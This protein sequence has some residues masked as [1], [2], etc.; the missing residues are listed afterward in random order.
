[1][2][3]GV[4]VRSRTDR[5]YTGVVLVLR[6]SRA[7]L[8]AVS[9][10]ALVRDDVVSER[11]RC[12]APSAVIY[13]EFL[14]NMTNSKRYC[15]WIANE[16][17]AVDC[18][19]DKRKCEVSGG[20]TYIEVNRRHRVQGHRTK[21]ESFKTSLDGRY[22]S[23]CYWEFKW[24]FKNCNWAGQEF[25][26]IDKDNFESPRKRYSRHCGKFR[27]GWLPNG[28]DE[29]N[30]PRGNGSNNYFV[31]GAFGK[32]RCFRNECDEDNYFAVSRVIVGRR[33]KQ[34]R[35]EIIISPLRKQRPFPRTGDNHPFVIEC[36]QVELIVG[37][38]DIVAA[39]QISDLSVSSWIATMN[40]S[41]QRKYR[42]LERRETK[43]I[44]KMPKLPEKVFYRI[45]DDGSGDQSRNKK[46]VKFQ[47]LGEEDNVTTCVPFCSDFSP[48]PA[49]YCVRR[50][51]I[52]HGW[53][54]QSLVL[55]YR[56]RDD[57]RQEGPFTSC[58][59]VVSR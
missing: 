19:G 27:R 32:R 43:K 1:M 47:L 34:N 11:L 33:E 42:S 18:S 25:L 58:R 4:R 8:A 9:F 5:G 57:V 51:C 20:S 44:P 50:P 3:R 13:C 59:N 21:I 28:I 56:L 36:K 35:E 23:R 46:H 31:I 2:R 29:D 54:V 53:D 38:I 10:Y 7:R 52:R 26:I 6:G 12:D 30:R 15:R 55:G 41:L 48:V 17:I 40:Y 45:L 37:L 22:S 14:I 16:P 24:R 49:R 39:V